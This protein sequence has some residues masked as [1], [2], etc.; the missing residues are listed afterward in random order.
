[1]NDPHYSTGSSSLLGIP[2]PKEMYLQ[3]HD[4]EPG[5]MVSLG[6]GEVPPSRDGRPVGVFWK[7]R[8]LQMTSGAGHG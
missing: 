1:M 4:V 5:K 3:C 7:D 2:S 6:P 8:C